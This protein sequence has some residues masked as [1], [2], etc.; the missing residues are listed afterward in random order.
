MIGVLMTHACAIASFSLIDGM[1]RW[2]LRRVIASALH[3]GDGGDSSND[4]NHENHG[5]EC[6]YGGPSSQVP[7]HHK[8]GTFPVAPA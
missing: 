7:N 2:L 5:E 1:G 4:Q 3:E 8:G 6:T